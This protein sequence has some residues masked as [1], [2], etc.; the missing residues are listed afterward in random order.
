[1]GMEMPA[2]FDRIS[3][4]SIEPEDVEGVKESCTIIHNLIEEQVR[5][6][7]AY[8][9][10]MIG[11]FSQGGAMALYSALRYPKRLA[12]VLALSCWLPLIDDF[13][14]AAHKE[15][16][17]IP[18]LQCHGTN[19]DMIRLSWIQSGSQLKIKTF[20]TNDNYTFKT[21]PNLGHETCF[22]EMIHA[23]EFITNCLGA[24]MSS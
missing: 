9:K 2:W 19:D 11:G 7:I 18:I 15:N 22:Q 12:G 16:L 14:E 5:T 13:P 4:N 17:T 24:S 23:K 8:D 1:M 3:F 6:G 21:Y 10:I 20:L